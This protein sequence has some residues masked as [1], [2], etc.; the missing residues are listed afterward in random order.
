MG[1]P[2]GGAALRGGTIAARGDTGLLA[3]AAWMRVQLEIEQSLRR[4]FA[5][6]LGAWGAQGHFIVRRG[7]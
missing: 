6:D 4:Q 2:A 5:V 7:L 3:V 1:M